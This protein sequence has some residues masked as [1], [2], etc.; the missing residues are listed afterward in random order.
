MF[1]YIF[2]FGVLFLC[3]FIIIK[4]IK[5]LI[6][7]KGDAKN[8]ILKI[9][10]VFLCLI[11]LLL[12]VISVDMKKPK[13][14]ND[15]STGVSLIASKCLSDT[16]KPETFNIYEFDCP[17]YYGT[18]AV[19]KISTE[20]KNRELKEKI[21]VLKITDDTTVAV[22][23]YVACTRDFGGLP[24]KCI[25][26]ILLYQEDVRVFIK[27][28]LKY[29]KFFGP[30]K[31]LTFTQYFYKDTVDIEEIANSIDFDS[32]YVLDETK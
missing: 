9:V 19:S 17:E 29:N 1:G 20:D 22:C 11:L 7:N 27:Y 3:L 26:T 30:L 31:Y 23:S 6:K 2:R 16:Y 14:D 4:S 12:S 18:V 21:Y 25:G 15:I 8:K 28:N 10:S 24:N 32:F 13:I 5:S